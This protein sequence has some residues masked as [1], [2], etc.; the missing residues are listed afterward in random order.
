MPIIKNKIKNFLENNLNIQIVFIFI[1]IFL[2]NSNPKIVF[3]LSSFLITILIYF[4]KL[5]RVPNFFQISLITP[6]ILIIPFLNINRLAATILILSILFLTFYDYKKKIEIKTKYSNFL[7]YTFFILLLIFS[8]DQN[9]AKINNVFIDLDRNFFFKAWEDK[10]KLRYSLFGFNPVYAAFLAIATIYL[11]LKENANFFKKF[12]FFSILVL[13]LSESKSVLVIVLLFLFFHYRIN[14][15][16]KILILCLIFNFLV[17]GFSY[18]FYKSFPSPYDKINYSEFIT[19]YCKP[20]LYE[21]RYLLKFNG[22]CGSDYKFE[23]DE[24]K[25]KYY[26]IFPLI[27]LFNKS[28]Y[29]RFHNIGFATQHFF[30]NFK[31]Y[32]IKFNFRTNKYTSLHT[33]YDEINKFNKKINPHNIIIKLILDLGL[34]YFVIISYLYYRLLKINNYKNP[35]LL[36]YIVFS[37]FHGPASLIYWPLLLFSTMFNYDKK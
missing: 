31:Y 34:L 27:D 28:N 12:L 25:L 32:L 19:T 24:Y 11:T 35:N 16:K 7:F 14:Y 1:I 20:L 8:F 26:T 13:F 15:L 3:L 36:V 17:I 37:T 18:K 6:I 10:V 33:K 22:I 29:Y 2:F 30:E 4:N 23:P 9:T 5:F 21:K